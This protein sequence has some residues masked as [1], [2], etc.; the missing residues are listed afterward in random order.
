MV[1]NEHIKAI[2]QCIIKVEPLRATG[3]M[4][5]HKKGPPAAGA[6]ETQLRSG[7]LDGRFGPP[8]ARRHHATCFRAF[9]NYRLV[10]LCCNARTSELQNLAAF[11]R[12]ASE[13][14]PKM[15]QLARWSPAQKAPKAREDMK[16]TC[17]KRDA[18]SRRKWRWQPSRETGRWPSWRTPSGFIPTRSI[19]GKSGYWTAQRASLRAAVA[20]AEGTASEAQV[21]LL[22]RQVG[23]PKVENDFLVRN[24]G[25]DPGLDPG[26]SAASRVGRAR[27]PGAAG[28][29]AMSAAGGLAFFGLSPADRG[30][31]RKT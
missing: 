29:A 23:Q 30:Q 11:G 3:V 8:R 18:G 1:R 9:S 10:A 21:D 28:I 15:R 16:R 6:R 5:Q 27:E 24:P 12:I 14:G 17:K 13:L 26:A 22:Y 19:T 4:M 31:A 7:Q 2:G 20:A 25:L